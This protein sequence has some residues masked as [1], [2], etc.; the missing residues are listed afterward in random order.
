M[1][2]WNYRYSGGY[3]SPELSV[4]NPGKEGHDKLDVKSA[5]LSADGKSVFLAIDDLTRA[6]QYSVKFTLN[7]ADG[8]EMRSEIIGT[9]HR[10]GP[11]IQTLD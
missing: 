7:A 10:L 6:D 3:G 5:I 9:I 8:A 2:L 1:E 11:A 4:K